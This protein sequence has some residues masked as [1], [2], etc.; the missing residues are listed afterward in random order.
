MENTVTTQPQKAGTINIYSLVTNTI[1]QQLENGV[2]PWQKPWKGGVAKAFKIPA[3]LV[4]GD[5]YRGINILLLWSSAIKNNFDTD[6]W[7]TFRQWQGKNESVRLNEKGSIIVKYDTIDKEIDGEQQKIPFI[8]K[9]YVF[10]RCQLVSYTPP[11][12]DDCLDIYSMVEKIDKVDE[13]IANTGALIETHGEGAV[14]NR[15][16]DK[17]LIPYPEK[18]QSTATCTATEGFYSTLMHELTHWTGAEHRINREKGKKFGDQNYANE[19]LVAEFGAAFLCAG[20][21]LATV[22][23]GDHAAYI[24]SWLQA[25][26]EDERCIFKAASAATKAVDFLYRLSI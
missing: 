11:K 6:E 24:S 20:F 22:E 16:E 18:F 4:T 23:K 25:L 14:Y 10:N 15:V 12:E 9:Y 3:N 26:K 7:A 2:I 19:E 21:G 1:I 5:R 17:I 8:K 13:F